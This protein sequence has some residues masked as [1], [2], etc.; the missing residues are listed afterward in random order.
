MFRQSQFGMGYQGSKLEGVRESAAPR[1]SAGLDFDWQGVRL[2]PKTKN[3][4]VQEPL[5]I[6]K[7]QTPF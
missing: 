4:V 2:T 7:W 5:K 6:Q 3:E 1:F